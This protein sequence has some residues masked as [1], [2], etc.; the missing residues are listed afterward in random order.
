MYQKI[1]VPI[2][3]STTSQR[4]L[5]EA[6]QLAQ[7]S[8]ASLVLLHIV[9]DAA[10]VNGFERPAAYLS[11]IRPRFLAAGQALLDAAKAGLA[12]T[13]RVVD[14]ALIECCGDRVSERIVE[15]ATKIGADLIVLGTHGRRGVDRLLIGS[16]AEQVARLAPV[17]VLLVRQR[18][19]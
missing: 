3:G 12:G 7:L 8:G 5:V 6:A 11:D 16:D 4:A 13:P 10:H 2:D 19:D 15:H 17:P 1:L 18:A 14:T 9:D